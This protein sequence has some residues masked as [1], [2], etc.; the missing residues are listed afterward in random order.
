MINNSATRFVFTISRYAL[1]FVLAIVVV[2]CSD[3]DGPAKKFTF[4]VPDNFNFPEGTD[5]WII[6]SDAKGKVL[7]SHK[8]EKS[9]TYLFTSSTGYSENSVTM[10]ILQY[11]TIW[12]L[13][14][15]YIW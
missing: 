13:P 15:I 9:D 1:C 8:L 7:D 2:C 11:R 10:T 6:L 12:L 3:D 4:N 5:Y 14:I